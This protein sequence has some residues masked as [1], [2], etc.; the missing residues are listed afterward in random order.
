M[1]LAPFI[2]SV[3]QKLIDKLL[4]CFFFFFRCFVLLLPHRYA[5]VPNGETDPANGVRDT[6]FR[7][8]GARD[9]R[10]TSCVRHVLI[11]QATLLMHRR[12]IGTSPTSWSTQ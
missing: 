5:M 12:P 7:H 10:H 4:E 9:V 3:P 1:F 8:A 2:F 11:R 6:S